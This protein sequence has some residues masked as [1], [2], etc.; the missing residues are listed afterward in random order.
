MSTWDDDERAALVALLR[1]RPQG[2]SWSRITAEVADLGSARALF[3][4]YCPPALFGVGDAGTDLAAEFDTARRDVAAW[5]TADFRFLTFADADYPAR[6]REVHEMPPV[7]FTRGRLVDADRAVSVVG[8]RSAPASA[9]DVAATIATALS[10]RGLTV[11]SGLAEGIDTAAHTA[12]LAAGGRTVAVIGTGIR[13]AYPASNRALQDRIAGDGLVISQF[14]P[15]AAPT[16]QSFPL[17]NATMSGY[18]LAT[19]VVAASELS[20][21]RIQARAAVAHGRPVILMEAVAAGT[22]W[23]Q[24]LLGQPD[25]FVARDPAEAVKH[26]EGVLADEQQIAALLSPP[27]E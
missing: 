22:N 9:L 13:R 18:G 8:S 10:E 2:M 21:A 5:R 24:A 15:D 3:D 12:A 6:L 20:G 16:R 19:I 14:W 17:R 26:V 27:R 25:V 1:A 11:L 23:G 7:L 4:R